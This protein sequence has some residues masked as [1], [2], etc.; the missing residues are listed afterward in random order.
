MAKTE[1]PGARSEETRDYIVI[2]PKL[3]GLEGKTGLL[4][5]GFN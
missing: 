2:K 4:D 1:L 5:V 3:Q